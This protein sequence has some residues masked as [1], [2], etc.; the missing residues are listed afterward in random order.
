[1][2][3]PAWLD[4][5]AMKLHGLHAVDVIRTYL[6]RVATGPPAW[7]KTMWQ[8]YAVQR[9]EGF[10]HIVSVLLGGLRIVRRHGRTW[11]TRYWSG[12]THCCR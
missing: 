4:K 12:A 6:E 1:M 5:S 3:Q 10:E 9:I 7:F 8:L 2:V 11:V